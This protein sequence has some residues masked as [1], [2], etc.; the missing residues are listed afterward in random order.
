MGNKIGRPIR[1]HMTTIDIT[2]AQ[3]ARVCVEVNFNKPLKL[4]VC[5]IGRV[6]VVKYEGLYRICYKCG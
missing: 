2:R 4:I 3:F 6:V 5:M 1:V